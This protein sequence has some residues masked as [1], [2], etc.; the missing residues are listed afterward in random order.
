MVEGSFGDLKQTDL[1]SIAS[2]ILG[3]PVP[4]SSLGIFHPAF[5]MLS[6]VKQMPNTFLD[7]INQLDRYIQ[8]YCT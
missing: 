2:S 7:N 5:F 1:A 4:F 6:D 8:E 3:V